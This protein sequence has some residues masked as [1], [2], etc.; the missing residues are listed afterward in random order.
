[1]T[2]PTPT[3]AVPTSR[4]SR[5]T[6]AIGTDQIVPT[7]NSAAVPAARTTWAPQISTHP[8]LPTQRSATRTLDI[9][10]QR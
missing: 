1:M 9:R 10:P 2:I 7:S 3:I 4:G 8:R 5:D 6:S